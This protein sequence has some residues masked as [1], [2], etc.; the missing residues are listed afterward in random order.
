MSADVLAIEPLRRV[1]ERGRRAV[2]RC[3]HRHRGEATADKRRLLVEA[4]REGEVGELSE[5]ARPSRP[6][7]GLLGDSRGRGLDEHRRGRACLVA[8]DLESRPPRTSDRVEVDDRDHVAAIRRSLGEPRCAETAEGAAVGGEEDQGVLGRGGRGGRTRW[9]SVCAGELDERSSAG[10]V[11][12]GAGPESRV[13]A[14]RHDHD[15]LRRAPADH[16]GEVPQGHPASP[17]DRSPRTRPPAARTRRA[18]S[19]R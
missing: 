5:R 4:E 18:S 13:V 19:C 7:A 2:S 14:V 8:R 1:A 3:R 10:C 15:R 9:A 17:R 16:E 11:V 12:V 6:G